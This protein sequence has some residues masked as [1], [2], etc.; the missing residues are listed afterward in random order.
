M[1]GAGKMLRKKG[2]RFPERPRTGDSYAAAIAD[3]LRTE[4]GGTH[5]ATKTVMRWTG[6]S[7]RTVKNWLSSRCG[8]SGDHL[9]RL[10]RESDTVLATVLALA[11]RNHHMVGGDIRKIR[12]SLDQ[13]VRLIDEAFPTPNDPT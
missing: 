4:L 6:A 10:A 2:K 1:I 12:D 5:R 8:P 3:A 13:V 7:E 9:I 11:D